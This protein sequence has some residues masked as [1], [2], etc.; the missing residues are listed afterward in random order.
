MCWDVAVP[1]P[2]GNVRICVDV[3]KLNESVCHER[4][5]LP[6][7]DERLAQLKGASIFSKLDATSGFWLI[8]L[9][10]ES[11]TL[12]TFITLFLFYYSQSLPFGISSAPER[13]QL[14]ISQ[15]IAGIPGTVCHA[16]DILVFG[17]N[18]KVHEERLIEVLKKFEK[19]GLT[20]N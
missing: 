6:N 16:D 7:V 19:T 14:R 1:K 2:N 8:P 15:M 13:F 3:T 5:I 9:H 17:K 4:R 20:L 18:K 10:I 11:E 12:T